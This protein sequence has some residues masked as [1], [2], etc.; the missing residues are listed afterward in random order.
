MEVSTMTRLCLGTMALGATL[1]VAPVAAQQPTYRFPDPAVLVGPGSSI[2]VHA[3]ELTSDD[4]KITGMTSVD[5]AFV[6]SVEGGT[7]AGKA[8]QERG[9]DRRVR[10]RSCPQRSHTLAARIGDTAQ[11]HRQDDDRSRWRPSLAR[12]HA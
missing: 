2:G 11:A 6:E 9:R 12:H 3:R 1:S 7:P 10:R 8:A 5:G 4:L